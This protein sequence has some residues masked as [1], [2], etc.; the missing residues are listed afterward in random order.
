MKR[1]NLKIK[2]HVHLTIYSLGVS[3]YMLKIFHNKKILKE[4]SLIFNITK[5]LNENT[6]EVMFSLYVELDHVQ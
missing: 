5:I 1:K 6:F 4:G 3:L 2:P